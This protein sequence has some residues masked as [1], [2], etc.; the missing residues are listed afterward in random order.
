M[1]HVTFDCCAPYNREMESQISWCTC[2]RKLRIHPPHGLFGHGRVC[3]TFPF[4]VLCDD[5]DGYSGSIDS[6]LTSSSV[7]E[8]SLASFTWAMLS[9]KYRPQSASCPPLGREG[10]RS[11]HEKL[12]PWNCI[13][14][15]RLYTVFI[16]VVSAVL[17][18][19]CFVRKDFSTF[20]VLWKKA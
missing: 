19:S 20:G 10:L 12:L 9:A 4:V 18:Q 2:E 11:M 7:D 8:A 1:L 6:G 13:A 14:G 17:H 5:T 15:G 3:T 16:F